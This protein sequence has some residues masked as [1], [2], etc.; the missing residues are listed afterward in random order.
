MSRK[1][2]TTVAT[3]LLNKDG[4][5]RL[6]YPFPN[7]ILVN[8]TKIATVGERVVT[9]DMKYCTAWVL[10]KDNIYVFGHS[11]MIYSED[12]ARENIKE[13]L[14]RFKEILT[15]DD[16][17][18]D[19]IM[20]RRYYDDKLSSLDAMASRNH[21]MC[22][23]E[24]KVGCDFLDLNIVNFE[25]TSIGTPIIMTDGTKIEDMARTRI[26]SDLLKARKAQIVVPSL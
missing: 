1:L 24:L 22:L 11:E 18:C 15:S 23:K 26:V 16:R 10:R 8:S 3:A 21:E 19:L 14:L 13:G 6:A 4:A 12:E 17:D 20:V 9:R 7:T 25:N 5:A 2:I